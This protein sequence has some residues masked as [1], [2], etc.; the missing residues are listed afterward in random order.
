MEMLVF[1][2]KHLTVLRTVAATTSVGL[3]IFI[4]IHILNLGGSNMGALLSAFGVLLLLLLPGG[5]IAALLLLGWQKV[6][7]RSDVEEVIEVKTKCNGECNGSC[8]KD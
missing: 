5:F 7:R 2:D 8:Y 3:Q 1:E 6:K 4:A